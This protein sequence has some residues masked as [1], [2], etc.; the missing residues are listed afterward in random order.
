MGQM[1]RCGCWA[2]QV[3]S[4]R[5]LDTHDDL[6]LRALPYG[7]NLH[8]QEPSCHARQRQGNAT[9]ASTR[10]ADILDGECRRVL[11]YYGLSL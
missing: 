4:K 6:L 9:V 2:G 1:G 3:E 10:E 5:S 11:E 8:L 7:T